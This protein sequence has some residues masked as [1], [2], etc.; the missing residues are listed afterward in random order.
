MPRSLNSFAEYS[1]IDDSLQF[2]HTEGS[3]VLDTNE[4]ILL[5]SR[6]LGVRASSF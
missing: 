6:A 5:E 2:E 1:A 4:I 3:N